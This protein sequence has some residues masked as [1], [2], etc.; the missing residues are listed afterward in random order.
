MPADA[1]QSAVRRLAFGESLT[2][3]ESAAAFGLI[4]S[5]EATAAQVAA[6]LMALRVKGETADEVAGAARALRGAMVAIDADGNM[7]PNLEPIEYEWEIVPPIVDTT[8][9]ETMIT[10]APANNSSSR[11]HG[12]KPRLKVKKPGLCIPSKSKPLER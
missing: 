6:L 2:A 10:L 4:M 8:A 7:D 3:D 1:L 12:Q 11:G 5:G 9:P